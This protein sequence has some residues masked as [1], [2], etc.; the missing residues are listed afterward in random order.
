MK[1]FAAAAVAAALAVTGS[2]HASVVFFEGFDG[3][4]PLSIAHGAT[5]GTTGNPI[6][7]AA[8]ST[9]GNSIST[10]YSYRVPNGD[11]TGPNSM[12]DEGT[13]T[14]GTNPEAVHS[15]WI[16]TPN[17][18]NPFLML[19]GATTT[20]SSVPGVSAPVAY[21]SGNIAVAA[22]TYNY[23]YDLLNLCCNSNGPPNTPSLLEL[24]YTD[25]NGN[26]TV[27]P[28]VSTTTPTA[29]GWQTV[30]G[31]FSVAQPGGTIRIGL[32]DN[33]SI[34]SGNDF[35]VDNITLATAG[36][37]EPASWALMMLGFGGLGAM[38]RTQRRRQAV[39]A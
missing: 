30:S 28:L 23:S 24:W 19:N 34:A 38:L 25:P 37:P 20:G 31:D 17:N 29:G 3:Y 39:A 27:I 32:V 4:S 35:G 9:T 21:E 5:G 18:T 16:A 22:G 1:L 7:P 26:Q 12:Y 8:T 2:A 6:V 15:L 36:V 14:I 33:T 11:N 10:D 13:W